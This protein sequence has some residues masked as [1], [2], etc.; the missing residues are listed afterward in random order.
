MVTVSVYLLFTFSTL[1]T[2]AFQKFYSMLTLV[3]LENTLGAL[4]LAAV[5]CAM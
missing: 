1:A 3:P 2:P 4:L 5:L